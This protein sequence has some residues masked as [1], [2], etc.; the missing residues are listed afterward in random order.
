[1]KMFADK[2]NDVKLSNIDKGVSF[3]VE[4][5][6]KF[7]LTVLRNTYSDPVGATVRE[8]AQ[9]A[10]EVDPN[11]SIHIPTSFEPWLAIRDNGTGLSP[12][13]T[14]RYFSKLGA[15]T[16][17]KDNTKVGGFGAGAKVLWA[18]TDDYTVTSRW[19][20]RMY[21]FLAYT[22]DFG[23]PMFTLA[24]AVDTDQPNGIEVR[25]PVKLDQVDKYKKACVQQLEFFD[26][27]PKLNIDLEWPERETIMAGKG[28]AIQKKQYGYPFNPNSESR[29]V[30]GNLSYPIDPGKF[31][32]KYQR[33]LQ[34]SRV[35]LFAPIGSCTLPMSRESLLYD[36]KT[37]ETIKGL[38]DTVRDDYR[39]KVQPEVDKCDTLAQAYSKAGELRSTYSQ[40]GGSSDDLKG[41]TYNGKP[42]EHPK[43]S[44]NI[45]SLD[46]GRLRLK[47]LSVRDYVRSSNR[48]NWLDFYEEDKV[49]ILGEDVKKLPSTILYN[50]AENGWRHVIYVEKKPD[51][52]DEDGNTIRHP[53]LKAIER[54]LKNAG[55]NVLWFNELKE[56]PKAVRSTANKTMARI[57]LH[58]GADH[59]GYNESFRWQDYKI[60]DLNFDTGV[61]VELKNYVPNDDGE[62][63][64]LRKFFD[65]RKKNVIPTDTKLFGIPGN[66]KNTLKDHA[67][68]ISVTE[69]IELA[70]QT[71]KDTAGKYVAKKLEHDAIM[72]VLS[73]HKCYNSTMR[74]H[75]FQSK[76]KGTYIGGLINRMHKV[77]EEYKE[78][79]EDVAFYVNAFV[80]DYTAQVERKENSYKKE[81]DKRYPMLTYTDNNV[82]PTVLAEYINM[83]EK[84]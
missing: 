67:N 28:Y 49:V 75:L 53:S 84:I 17:D 32:S 16:K 35:I 50:A 18:V 65:M 54:V 29:L 21:T 13:D 66:V 72:Q 34:S 63:W 26:P 45:Y 76:V 20:G 33:M 11:F 7:V 51:G 14:E 69:A 47:S 79:G 5:G 30:M 25:V 46:K 48:F 31:D 52:I 62:R 15:S 27:K 58:H 43:L 42:I 1:M 70:E 64:K 78:H 12:D 38:L 37:I 44:C 73:K 80:E 2:V 57:K 8:I 81:L 55:L 40:M 82:Q 4:D 23:R 10:S 71:L 60:D 3:D 36:D 74:D 83:M 77:K 61:Y 22:D 39:D 41:L 6:G 59:V 9:N 19:N 24:N 56:P 68:Y